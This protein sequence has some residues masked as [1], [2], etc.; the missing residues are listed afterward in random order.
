MTVVSNIEYRFLGEDDKSQYKEVL[1]SSSTMMTIPKSTEWNELLINNIDNNFLSPDNKLVGAFNQGRLIYVLGAHYPKN[2][3]YWY[4]FNQLSNLK[5]VGLSY[6]NNI[7]FLELLKML[8]VYGEEHGYYSFYSRRPLT[9]QQALD[10]MVE[11]LVHLGLVEKRY[12]LYYDMVYPAN[13]E[14]KSNMHRFYFSDFFKTYPIDTVI[15][16]HTLKQEYRLSL[17]DIP[18]PL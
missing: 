6:K 5:I 2:I 12:T 15:V 4:S 16:F 18:A 9:H 10:K 8:I 17:F 11:K 14:C 13:T 1:I 7:H 3:S